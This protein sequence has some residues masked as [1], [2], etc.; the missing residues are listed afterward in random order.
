[1][2][3]LHEAEFIQG[4]FYERNIL[5]QPGPLTLPRAKRSLDEPSYRIIDFG[6]GMSPGINYSRPELHYADVK[7]ERRQAREGR[8]ID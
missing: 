7:T 1:M 6:R 8:L 3:R 4:S 5:V 2:N